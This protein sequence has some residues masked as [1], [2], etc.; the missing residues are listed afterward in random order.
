MQARSQGSLLP[1][2]EGTCT[3]ENPG[4][5]VDDDVGNDRIVVI[6][7]DND[8]YFLSKRVYCKF[9]CFW[10]LS[11]FLVQS[12]YTSPCCQYPNMINTV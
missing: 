4:N 12:F 9:S 3:V 10:P 5:E 1:V 2:S 6:M 8:I 7:Y 11:L